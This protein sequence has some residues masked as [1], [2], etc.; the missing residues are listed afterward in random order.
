MEYSIGDTV[1]HEL[2]GKG[3]VVCLE[4]DEMTVRLSSGEC[5][6]YLPPHAP[7]ELLWSGG[8]ELSDRAK[9]DV[10]EYIVK[11]NCAVI[12]RLDR[13]ERILGEQAWWPSESPENKEPW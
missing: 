3:T 8:T 4:G 10:L 13:I 7:I 12:E 6:R 9:A 11:Q 5:K 1:L 2:H